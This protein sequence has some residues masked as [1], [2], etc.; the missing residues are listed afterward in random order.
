MVGS[1]IKSILSD[2]TSYVAG[3][4]YP[5]SPGSKWI[6]YHMISDV[7]TGTK[8][9]AS[10]LDMYRFQIDC[11]GRTYSDADTLAASVRSA[12]DNY[13]QGTV[14]GV[15]IEDIRF[16]GQ[17]DG[18]QSIEDMESRQDYYRRIQ[19]YIIWVKP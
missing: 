4:R 1:A 16:D 3:S 11:Y 5:D 6:I 12:L 17:Y 8:D 13:G 10:T 18:V 9:A 7:P 15:E 19:D 14:E 2:V